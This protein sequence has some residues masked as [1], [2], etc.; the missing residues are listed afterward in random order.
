MTPAKLAYLKSMT[1]ISALALTAGVSRQTVYTALN[2]TLLPSRDVAVRLASAACTL[3]DTSAFEASD[4]NPT[5]PKSVRNL[6]DQ[7]FIIT[8][9]DLNS[10]VWATAEELLLEYSDDIDLIS[11]LHDCVSDGER[12]LVHGYLLVELDNS[13]DDDLSDV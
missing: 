11:A 4:F 2:R 6:T 7:R 8:D 3:C 9:L 10:N 12:Q 5:L 1:S 13:S